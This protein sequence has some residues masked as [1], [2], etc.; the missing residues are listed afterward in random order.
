M[1]YIPHEWM[2]KELITAEKL[3][4]IENGVKEA[5]EA[6]GGEAAQGYAKDA[7]A[8]KT[9]AAGSATDAAEMAFGAWR[10]SLYHCL[11]TVVRIGLSQT[12][13]TR[14]RIVFGLGAM[15]ML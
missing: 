9:A 10:G 6:S 3:N 8:S 11:L 4:H 2:N 1:T 13:D 14:T 5:G 7:Q 12:L 15:K